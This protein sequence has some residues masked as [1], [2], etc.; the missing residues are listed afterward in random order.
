[1]QITVKVTP[2]ARESRII[3]IEGDLVRVKVSAPPDKGKAN[4]AVI[5]LLAKHYKV[6]KRCIIIKS[7]HTSRL[8]IVLI[9][10]V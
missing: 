4:E 1:M 6:P 8:K 7:G 9:E 2:G 10:G 3:S 5:D